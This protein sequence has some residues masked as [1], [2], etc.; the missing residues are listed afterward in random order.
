[1]VPN[2]DANGD[3]IVDPKTG[4]KILS[5]TK[6]NARSH[7]ATGAMN[8]TST[9]LKDATDGPHGIDINRENVTAT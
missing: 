5:R 1:M 9:G 2:F 8:K 3:Y 4:K 6:V 7:K